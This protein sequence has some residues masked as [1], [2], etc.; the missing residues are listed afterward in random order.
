MFGFFKKKQ[1]PPNDLTHRVAGSISSL[2]NLQL[3]M[4]RSSTKIGDDWTIGYVGGFAEQVSIGK[5]LGDDERG[6]GAML[7][8]FGSV[9][10]D[11][12]RLAFFNRYDSLIQA[13]DAMA[14]EGY[15]IARNEALALLNG[16]A[17]RAMGLSSYC[18]D[19]LDQYVEV[20]DPMDGAS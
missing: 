10:G 3:M 14:L 1:Q 19:M 5:G 4:C 9:F 11:Q 15:K 20:R 7:L 13:K 8:V 18:L 12:N 16:A 2:L 6:I 17:Q